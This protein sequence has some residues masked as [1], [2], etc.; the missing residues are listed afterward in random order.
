MIFFDEHGNRE[1]PTLVCV[2]GLL[3]GPADFAG[4]WEQW[5]HNYHVIILDPDRARWQI[6]PA[7]LTA[8][9]METELFNSSSKDIAEVLTSVGK[10]QAFLIGV[11][12]GGKIVYDFASK[13]PDRFLGAVVIDVGPGPFEETE[14]FRFIDGLVGTLDLNLPFAE[15]KQVLRD[16]IP[17]RNLRTMIQ[18]QIFYPNGK[19]PARWK[20]GMGNFG[21]IFVKMLKAQN[22]NEQFDDLEAVDARLAQEAHSI[23]VLQATSL[24]AI[25]PVTIPRI[26]ALKSLRMTTING[27]SHFMHVT[28]KEPITRAV[29]EMLERAT[30]FR[31]PEDRQSTSVGAEASI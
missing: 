20:T 21:Q 7:A 19:P 27:T 11:S 25:D 4:M 30:G 10:Q 1:N 24:S 23:H 8:Q 5:L 9:E 6:A 13:Y 15:L 2:P 17:E 29:F 22:I 3:G 18:T 16:T 26:D 28:T 12:L 31:L 14:L